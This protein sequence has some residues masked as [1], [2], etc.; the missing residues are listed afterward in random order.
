MLARCVFNT[1][2]AGHG[3]RSFCFH[4]CS[5][6]FQSNR[7]PVVPVSVC[8]HMCWLLQL[9]LCMLSWIPVHPVIRP[10]QSLYLRFTP[11]RRAPHITT[12]CIPFACFDPES[13]LAMVEL[14]DWYSD[15]C[16]CALMRQKWFE[17][18]T[19]AFRCGCVA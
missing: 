11:T 3:S 6:V 2:C 1:T 18:C 15:W 12:W 9:M 17:C 5:S 19:N 14:A 10:K 13:W 8:K 4:P 7:W 16:G